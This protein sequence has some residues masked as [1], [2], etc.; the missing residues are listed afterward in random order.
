MDIRKKLTMW[1]F[2]ESVIVSNMCDTFGFYCIPFTWYD[3]LKDVLLDFV[4]INE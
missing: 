2:T 3:D 1:L 4:I